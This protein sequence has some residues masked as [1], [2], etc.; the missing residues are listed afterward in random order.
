MN[1]TLVVLLCGMSAALLAFGLSVSRR[2]QLD[3]VDTAAE[4]R[5]V[6]RSILGHPRVARFLR[7][8]K[9]VV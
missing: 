7:D 5:A 9:S 2:V 6:R 3:P 4:E 8:R 1:L